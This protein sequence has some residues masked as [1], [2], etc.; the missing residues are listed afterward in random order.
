[1]K[2]A[3]GVRIAAAAVS[4]VL[5]SL[6]VSATAAAQVTIGQTA[7]AGAPL[8]NCNYSAPWD[9]LQTS[10]ASGTSYVVPTAGVITSWSTNP[11]G[12]G[13]RLGLKVFRP[14]GGV[15]Y[16]VV[17]HD[18]PLVLTPLVLN[19]FAVNIPVQAGDVIGIHLPVGAGSN[20]VFE[21]LLASDVIG[22]KEGDAPDGG[23]ITLEGTELGGRLNLAAT[24][25]PPPTISSFSP[26]KGS[27]FGAKVVITGANFASVSAVSFGSVSAKSFTVDS[28]GQITAT[29]PA[30]KTLSKVPVTVTTIAGTAT[31]AQLFAYQGCRVPKLKGK[32]LKAAKK[33]ARKAGCAIGKVKKLD[34]ATAKNGKVVKQSPKP[35]KLLP[36]GAKIKVTLDD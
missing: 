33:R 13:G 31:S 12:T 8:F 9:E 35:G 18:G 29:A 4:A 25:L 2:K 16:Q 11:G 24:L 28:E 3:R 14:V 23:S 19:T 1:V 36:P 22:F 27:I 30:S 20:C 7:P 10:V 32:S 6:A 34:G 17:A 26:P 5:V 21:T 15:T